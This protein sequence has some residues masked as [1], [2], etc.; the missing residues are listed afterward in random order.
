MFVI[1]S[2]PQCYSLWTMV[3]IPEK[4]WGEHEVAIKSNLNDIFWKGIFIEMAIISVASENQDIF[5]SAPDPDVFVI[6]CC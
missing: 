4:I 3:N 1:F 6:K 2:L 5:F